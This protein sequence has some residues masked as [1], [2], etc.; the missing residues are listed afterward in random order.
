MTYLRDGRGFGGNYEA[1][2]CA[3]GMGGCFEDSFLV[4]NAT[5]F[6]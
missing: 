6:M 1:S 4:W 5:D 3:K 2:V